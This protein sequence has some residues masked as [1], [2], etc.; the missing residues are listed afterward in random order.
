[1]KLYFM[2]GLPTETD[3]DVVAIAEL[4]NKILW[5]WK[6]HATNKNRGVRL[7]VSTSCFVPKAHTAF[8]WEA[9][10]TME[11]Y[12]RRVTLLRENIRN[13]AI[14]YNWHE[15][16]GSFIEAVLARG[17]RRLGPVIEDVWRR[18]GRLESWSEHFSLARWMAAFEAAGID[19]HFYANRQRGDDEIFPW[20]VIDSGVSRQFL[21]R[22]R[23]AAYE[24]RLSPDCRKACTA[25]G[26]TR[27]GKGVDC[28][29]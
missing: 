15:P 19:P 4:A 14:T 17:D 27:I 12:L 7:T 10:V 18:G 6:Q 5:T 3:E 21:A 20:D 8:Q 16:E 24:N 28:H 9:G 11:E 2:L 29:G 23:D 1:M 22:E 25:C 26:V 13:R